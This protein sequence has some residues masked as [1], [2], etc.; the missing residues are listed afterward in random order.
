MGELVTACRA[1]GAAALLALSYDGG[2]EWSFFD[3][4]AARA[5][6]PPDPIDRFVREA[7]NA[8]Q[9]RD[10]GLGPALGPDAGSCAR[11]LFREA[12]YEVRTGG[13]PWI[14][15]PADRDLAE[16]LVRGWEVA[17]REERSDRAA[18]VHEWSR[19]KLRRI[20]EEVF[21]LRVGHVDLLALP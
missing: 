17:A 13:A 20:R 19:R 7:V 18:E 16:G 4:A 6:E 3:D 1:A 10:K 2:I 14:L 11:D 15:G 9:R 8:H 5:S 12:G 21:E